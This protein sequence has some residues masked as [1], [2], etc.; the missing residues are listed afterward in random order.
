MDTHGYQTSAGAGGEDEGLG[1]QGKSVLPSVGFKEKRE[2]SHGHS[3]HVTNHSVLVNVNVQKCTTESK[4]CQI[5][6]KYPTL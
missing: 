5:T 4:K 3:R 1:S 2:N 6:Q